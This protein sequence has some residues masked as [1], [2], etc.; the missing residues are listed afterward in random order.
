MPTSSAPAETA[1]GA[2]SRASQASA[3]RPWRKTRKLSTFVTPPQRRGASVSSSRQFERL[4]DPGEDQGIGGS[5]ERVP[6]PSSR[7]ARSRAAPAFSLAT[8]QLSQKLA[9]G[10][11]SRIGRKQ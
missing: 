3:P 5:G 2:A 10:I 7:R 8:F 4:A 1:D 6:P 9:P 11:G